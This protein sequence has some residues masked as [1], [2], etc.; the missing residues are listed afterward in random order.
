MLLERGKA[1]ASES[2]L[3][4]D[5]DSF[6]PKS[7]VEAGRPG[8]IT[9]YPTYRLYQ[10]PDSV[11][12]HYAAVTAMLRLRQAGGPVTPIHA[13]AKASP[14]WRLITRASPRSPRRLNDFGISHRPN[15]DTAGRRGF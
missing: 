8:E 9:K 6:R 12:P 2:A 14:Q 11:R 10:S 13:E 4:K 5:V 7:A 15:R 3:F 1:R